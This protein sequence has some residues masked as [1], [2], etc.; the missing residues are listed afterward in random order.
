MRMPVDLTHPAFRGLLDAV[1][2]GDGAAAHVLADWLPEQG[3]AAGDVL[4]LY[5][6]PPDWGM[7]PTRGCADPNCPWQ[8]PPPPDEDDSCRAVLAAWAE[9][10]APAG[11]AEAVRELGLRCYPDMPAI[12]RWCVA[13]EAGECRCPRDR[14]EIHYPPTELAARRALKRAVLALWDGE[15]EVP[16][17]ACRGPVR[18]VE[19][20]WQAHG[21]CRVC[22]SRG[23]VKP[24]HL[25]PPEPAR[26]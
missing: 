20:T 19:A 21:P 11:R 18:K 12:R 8:L 9:G 17:P 16:C 14:T 1:R 25:I 5:A 10:H 4:R 2:R 3:A 24:S 6:A 7:C 23:A 15:V 22:L 26:A 13:N